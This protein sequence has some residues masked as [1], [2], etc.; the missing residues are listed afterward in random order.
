MM[1]K[2][3][4]SEFISDTFQT[5]EK[6]LEEVQAGMRKLGIDTLVKQGDK[7]NGKDNF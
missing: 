1:T 2:N 7:D 5:N 3:K 6:D 4:E